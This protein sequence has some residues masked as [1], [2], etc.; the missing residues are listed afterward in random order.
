MSDYQLDQFLKKYLGE[1]KEF[2]RDF[3]E[4]LLKLAW[5]EAKGVGVSEHK[6]REWSDKHP[7]I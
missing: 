4:L 6:D 2:S 5:E 7:D 3:V 1:K